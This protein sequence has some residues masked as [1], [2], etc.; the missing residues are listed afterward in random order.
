LI[1]L[2]ER[3]DQILSSFDVKRPRRCCRPSNLKIQHPATVRDLMTQLSEAEVIGDTALVRSIHETL[4]D[5]TVLPAKVLI[6][7]E[8]SRPGYFGTWTKNS[9][10][11]GPRSPLTKD[12][13]DIDYSYDSGEDWEEPAGDADD[14]NDDEEEDRETEDQDSDM[15]DWLVDDDEV[16]ASTPI[17]ERMGSPA[18]PR[19]PSPLPKRKA[20]TTEDKASKKRKVVIPL[21]PFSKG[22]CWEHVIGQCEESVF[23]SY[24]I[25]LLNGKHFIHIYLDFQYTDVT[26]RYPI[27]YRPFYFRLNCR[28]QKASYQII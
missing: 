2:T 5:R 18:S 9:R 28:H 25:R 26:L 11:I 15:D 23:N 14:V 8:D 12:V 4:G 6:F 3:L 17:S 10:L 16:E 1:T 24:Q 21:V 22:P 20:T 7:N 27:L 13:I 19:F